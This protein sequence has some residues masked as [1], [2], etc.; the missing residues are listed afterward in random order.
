MVEWA[1]K[2][3]KPH[4]LMDKRA[5]PAIVRFQR[6]VIATNRELA[7]L[8]KAHRKVLE[9]DDRPK[10]MAALEARDNEAG[11]HFAWFSELLSGIPA[12]KRSAAVDSFLLFLHQQN[13]FRAI[14][15]ESLPRLKPVKGQGM[16]K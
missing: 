1:L 3:F 4:G 5:A 8:I 14:Y 2:D 7:R 9:S 11:R 15:M 6:V 16:K 12:A 10:K 13:R